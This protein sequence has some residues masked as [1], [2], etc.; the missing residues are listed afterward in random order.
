[1]K[2][3]TSTAFITLALVAV[4]CDKPGQDTQ[5]KRDQAQTELTQAQTE[6][7]KKVDQAKSDGVKKIDQAQA[8]ADQKMQI[9]NADFQKSVADYRASRQKDLADADKAIAD[10]TT[11]AA[12]ATGKKKTDLEAALPGIRTR[13]D[14]FAKTWTALD[15]IT[16]AA[17]D[18]TKINIDKSFDELKAAIKNAS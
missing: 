6:A 16:P 10:L 9:A 8:T 2:F 7:T 11:A 13:R 18:A 15:G 4:A 1:M 5:Q 17:F 3:I 12:T 14:A